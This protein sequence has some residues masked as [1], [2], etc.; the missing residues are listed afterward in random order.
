MRRRTGLWLAAVLIGTGVVA[1]GAPSAGAA[2]NVWPHTAVNGFS[3]PNGK[4]FWLVYAD[5]T[6]TGKGNAPLHGDASGLA[7]VGADRRRRGGPHR[8]RLLVGRE[9]RR[10][11][12][13]RQCAV[14][15]EHGCFASQPARV[16]DVADPLRERLLARR[17]RRRR[18]HVRRRQVLRLDGRAP[19]QPTDRRHHDQPERSRIPN[20]RARWRNLQF[21]RRPVLREPARSRRL[22]IRCRGHGPDAD[23]QGLLD[24]AVR[25]EV[26]I[27]SAT[28]A[29]FGNYT[30]SACDLVS[31]IF[32]NPKAEG[33]RLVLQSGATVAF[34]SAPGGTVATGVPRKCTA[35]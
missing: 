29:S 24:R 6:V 27:R 12:L 15:R 19:S 30:P 5:G 25:T 21:R 26:F 35:G 34:G 9:R 17:A 32:S 20:G 8:R 18:L 13:V 23:Q 10:D 33:Y 31:A 2:A 11:L 7:P 3:S 16:L 4:G 1:A 28:R 22:G 14:P